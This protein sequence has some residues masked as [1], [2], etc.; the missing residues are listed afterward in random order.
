MYESAN[1]KSWKVLIEIK[2]GIPG[3]I[4]SIE[5]VVQSWTPKVTP[6]MGFPDFIL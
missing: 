3:H 2:R 6:A 5:L 1:L 4:S